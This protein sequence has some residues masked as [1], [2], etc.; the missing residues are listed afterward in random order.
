MNGLRSAAGLGVISLVVSMLILFLLMTVYLREFAP[1]G[2]KGGTPGTALEAT[3]QRA[4]EFRGTAE[5]APRSDEPGGFAVPVNP[6]HLPAN[7]LQ[8]LPSRGDR[9]AAPARERKVRT[10]K[11]RMAANGGPE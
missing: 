4:H 10:P 2:P 8:V 11:D 7:D 5:A 3:K 6:G 9:T 1:T